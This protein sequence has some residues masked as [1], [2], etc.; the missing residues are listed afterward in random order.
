MILYGDPARV[1]FSPR[2]P[3]QISTSPM[4]DRSFLTTTN[5]RTHSEQPTNAHNIALMCEIVVYAYDFLCL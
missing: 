4:L 2:I 1:K 5:K 3:L